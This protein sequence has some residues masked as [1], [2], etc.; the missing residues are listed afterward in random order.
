M[1]TH[2]KRMAKTFAD[3]TAEN[4]TA[5]IPFIT[6]GD[7]QAVLT[8]DIMHALVAGGA[9]II[10]LG[11]PFSDPAADGETIQHAS[12]R[13]IHNGI[14]YQ[15]TF[16][17]VRTFRE[18]NQTTPVLLMG[19][20]NSAEIHTDGFSGFAKSVVE[21]GADA[22]IL[23]DLSYESGINYR[24]ILRQHGIDLVNLISPTTSKTRLGKIV[25]N[26][27]GFVYYVSMRG[28]TGHGDNGLNTAE[29]EQAI[30]QIRKKSNLPVCIGFGIK[31]GETA[32]A[33]GQLADGIVV[34]SALVKKL[35]T[36]AQNNDNVCQTATEFM[37]ELRHALDNH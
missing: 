21:C 28:V 7:P 5:L 27:G 34:G 13:A 14:G 19:Y 29:I 10:E 26:A 3:L 24:S 9:N 11:I 2:S 35:Y 32:K 25:K 17:A 23:V 30:G 33:V 15:D 8:T 18:K 12:E 31:D 16:K 36:A 1:N 4:K 22:V 6:T 20:L 37:T